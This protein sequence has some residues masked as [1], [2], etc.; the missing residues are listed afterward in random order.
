MPIS[1]PRTRE[2]TPSR[3]VAWPSFISPT[4]KLEP[5]SCSAND[6][7]P[8]LKARA[9]SF[10]LLKLDMNRSTVQY[11]RQVKGAIRS[12]QEGCD[13][14]TGL[15]PQHS[16]SPRNPKKVGYRERTIFMAEIL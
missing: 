3:N 9:Q 2:A 6:C 11:A 16:S 10:L 12:I 15:L 7:P 8:Y 1:T 4:D 5:H 14:A 13:L